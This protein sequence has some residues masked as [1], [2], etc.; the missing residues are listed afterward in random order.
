[1]TGNSGKPANS[2][3]GDTEG[4][5]SDLKALFDSAISLPPDERNRYIERECGPNTELRQE[6]ESLLQAYE[7]TGDFLEEPVASLRPF[8][9]QFPSSDSGALNLPATEPIAL[10]QPGERIGAYRLESELGRGGMGAVFLATRADGEFHQQVA[11][12]LIRRGWE[13]DFA[14]RRF[15]HERQILA[16]LDHPHIARLLDGGTTDAGM[17]YF[18]MEYVEGR[19]VTSFCEEYGLNTQGRVQ[20]F[21]RICSAV[22]YAHERNVIHR[23]LKPGNILV[24]AD[25]TP[26]LLDFGIAKLV[27]ADASMTAVDATA[28]GFRLL[29]PAYASPEQMRGDAATVRSDVYSLGIILYELLWGERPSLSAIQRGLR[30]TG[31]TQSSHLSPELQSIVF[32]AIQWDPSDRYGSVAELAEDLDLYQKGSR[33]RS[34]GKSAADTDTASALVSIAILPLRFAAE[35][36]EAD[37]YLATGITDALVSRLSRVE[38]LS[39]RPTSATLKYDG[40][41]DTGRAAR[42]LKV[43]YILEGSVHRVNGLV[44]VSLQLVYTEASTT[45]WAAQF[46]Q[47]AEDLIKLEESIAEEVASALLPRLSGEERA[48]IGRAGTQNSKAH[49]AYLR[50][51]WHWSRSAG[52]PE[53]LKKA[54][55]CFSQAIAEDENYAL[56]HAGLADYYLRLGLWGGLPPAESFAAAMDSAQRA[57]RLDPSS[58]EAHA[59]LGFASWAYRRDYRSAEQH[60]HLAIIRNPDYGSAHHW[61]GLLNSARNEP[62]L[63]I[64]NLERAH[65][66]EP[67]SP[68]IVAALGFVHYNAR[69]YGKAAQLLGEAAKE[70]RNSAVVQE[71]LAWCFLKMGDARRAL[72]CAQLAVAV[73]SRSPSAL[74]VLAHALAA[75]GDRGGALVLCGEIDEISRSRYVS[76]YD[77]ASAYLAAGDNQRAI[78]SLEAAVNE[79]DWWI[80]WLGVEPRWDSLRQN[81][82]FRKLVDIVQPK[83]E[84][85]ATTQIFHTGRPRRAVA[86]AASALLLLVLGGAAFLFWLRVTRHGGAFR[87]LRITKITANGIANAAAISPNGQLV[88]YTTL[89]G[90]ESTLMLRDVAS[91]RARNLAHQVKGNIAALDFTNNGRSVSFVSYA[92]EQA[93]ERTL[94]T[95]ALESDEPTKILGPFGGGGAM[96]VD[97]ADAATIERVGKTDELWVHHLK[98]GEKRKIKTYLYPERFAWVCMPAWSPDG[99]RIAYAAEQRDGLGFLLRLFVIDVQSGQN[100][101]NFDRPGGTRAPLATRMDRRWKRPCRGGARTGSTLPAGVVDSA[102]RRR[103][104]AHRQRP[105]QYSSASIT[106]DSKDMVSVQVRTESNIYI[107]NTRDMAVRFKSL[108]AADDISISPGPRKERYVRF[109]CDRISRPVDDECG[110]QRSEA[111]LFRCGPQLCHR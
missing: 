105:G 63:A 89:S 74:S 51:R 83:V 85:D 11:I 40:Q 15:R 30:S 94:F 10:V 42:E 49:E 36:R 20:L 97:G 66:V 14:I 59:S 48:Q 70:L 52:D 108:Q 33:P 6:L 5:W 46:D 92:S 19:P 17:P 38:R 110:R 37:A 86:L 95:V 77:R 2:G 8:A 84:H 50:G 35:Q 73:S 62:E 88:A 109:R 44:R 16:G 82:R 54:L 65:Q 29:T 104:Q 25:A 13:S 60:F 22:H 56:A 55:L 9:D 27:A 79:S 78:S 72:D 3:A 67:T 7:S 61:F 106:A 103:C 43:K 81:G 69:D 100:R 34:V 39:V 23:D 102:E 18:V 68:V 26:K 1:M 93:S 21:M 45:V 4:H 71:M 64:A 80:S 99:R 75:S 98:T 96:T 32:Q 91:G 57:L 76:S 24:R 31:E 53:E 41:P 101:K 87:D 90:G 58:G 107:A 47:A 12:K 28:A 111:T